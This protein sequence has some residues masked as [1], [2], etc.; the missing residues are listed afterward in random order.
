MSDNTQGKMHKEPS[1]ITKIKG[2]FKPKDTDSQSS[3]S[4]SSSAPPPAAAAAVASATA[5]IEPS[6]VAK[7][8]DETEFFKE[9]TG[10]SETEFKTLFDESENDRINELIKI[11]SADDVL[12][13]LTDYKKKASDEAGTYYKCGGKRFIF[14]ST[15]YDAGVF[16][17]PTIEELTKYAKKNNGKSSSGSAASD[18]CVFN[19]VVP[20]GDDYSKC[21]ITLVQTDSANTNATFQIAS[22]LNT[23]EPAN[24]DSVPDDGNFVTIYLEDKTQGPM[25][26]IS[27]APSAI[28][29]VY[30]MFCGGAGDSDYSVWPQSSE[31]QISMLSRLTDF[32]TVSNGYV[33][34][35]GGEKQVDMKDID[36]LTQKVR[37]GMQFNTDVVFGQRKDGQMDVLEKPVKIN[38]VFCAG[39]NEGQGQSGS[40]NKELDKDGVKARLI[41]RACYQGT[42]LAAVCMGSEKLFLTL[43]GGGVFGNAVEVIAEEMAKAHMDIANNKKINGGGRLKEVNLLLYSPTD[44]VVKAVV[45]KLC[46]RGVKVTSNSEDIKKRIEAEMEKAA[47]AAAAAG[48]TKK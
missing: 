30:C 37:I 29:R 25:A 3:S 45:E 8:I 26:S 32:Y 42:Y 10:V 36:K 9:V 40:Q 35:Y 4:S 20:A 38:Q 23:M 11:E 5:P 15:N 6:V 19:I 7:T 13:G 43:V 17:F 12:K 1:F 24:E 46:E 44:S 31:A 14:T 18:T 2:F 33:V 39:M 16:L 47:A 34:N 28:T 41:Q 22:N 27:A 21:D 48:T